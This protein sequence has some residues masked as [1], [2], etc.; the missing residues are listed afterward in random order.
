VIRPS[1]RDRPRRHLHRRSAAGGVDEGNGAGGGVPPLRLI[2]LL[3]IAISG[4]LALTA[5]PALALETHV[6]K[7]SF[8]SAGS[9][10]GQLAL[11]ENSGVAID[12]ATGDVYVADTGN[13]RVSEFEAD[14]TF[15]R[16]FGAF[17]TPTYIA[18]DNS[19]GGEGDVYVAD[20]A[21]NL[22]SKF[23][24]DGTPVTGWGTAGKLDITNLPTTPTTIGTNPLLEV[25]PLAGIAVGTAGNLFVYDARGNM[26]QFGQDGSPETVFNTNFG[27]TPVGIAVDSSNNLYL[28]R[29]FPAVEKVS[30]S[31][32]ELGLIAETE[33][34][35]G[36]TVDPASSELFVDHGSELAAFNPSG[37]RVE[38]FSG[39]G[40][41]F[42]Q[43]LAVDGASR[44][45]FVASAG[46]STIAVFEAASLPTPITGAAS[47][48]TPTT[49]TLHGEV[50]PE[51]A[52]LTECVFEYGLQAG[53]GSQVPCQQS[54][55]EIG[56]G[57][58]PVAVTANL[59]GLAPST[60]YHF[61]L[62]AANAKGSEAGAD[63][64]LRTTGP[65]TI[66]AQ[67]IAEPIAKTAATIE[68][69]I[70]PSGFETHAWVEYGTSASYGSETAPEALGSSTTD[71]ALTAHLTGL[72]AGTAYH[73]R[74]VAENAQGTVRSGQDQ[75][76]TT[77]APL[78][79]DSAS[80][81]EVS[82]TSATLNAQINPLGTPTTY[83]FEYDTTPYAE[84]EAAHGVSVPAPDAGASSGNVDI[85]RTA[86]IQ[87]LAPST[88]YHYRVVAE[89]ALDR[90][91][92]SDRIF[93]T[94]GSASAL[95]PDGRQWELASPPDKH[96]GLLYGGKEVGI[97]QAAA[98]GSAVS[99]LANAPTEA[100][101]Q[102]SAEGIQV[103]STRG[104]AGW[105]SRDIVLPHEA[106]PGASPGTAPEYRF[107]TED[108]TAAF[109][110]PFG[111]FNPTLSPEGS[112]QT[113]YLHALGSCQSSCFRPLVTAADVSPHGTRF[114][115][116]QL[117]EQDVEEGGTFS[118]AETICGP[119]FEGATGDARHVVIRSAAP[120]VIGAPPGGK[121]SGET[122][123]SLYEWSS[124]QLQLISVLPPNEAGE[125]LPAP[126]V[127][128]LEPLLGSGS[129]HPRGTARRAISAD[130][131]RIVWEY[132]GAI[133]LRDTELGHEQ[134][135]QLDSPEADCAQCE[136]EGGAGRFQIASTDGS[137]V[138]FTDTHRLTAD[139]GAKKDQPD[140]YEC[141][142]SING[143]GV[144]SCALTDLTPDEGGKGA[145]VQGDVIGASED[146]TMIYFV[147]DGTLGGAAAER[148]T[149]VNEAGNVQPP[150]ARCNLYLLRDGHSPRLVASLSGAD[151]KDWTQFQQEQPTRVSPDGHWLTFMSQRSLTGYDNTDAV[152]RQPDAEIFLYDDVGTGRLSCA[153]CNPTG[154]RPVGV[155]YGS[156]TISGGSEK[157]PTT[158]GQWE[159]TGW[160]AALV[161][162]VEAFSNFKPSYQPRYLN[163]SG[164]LYFNGLDALVPQDTNAT[165]DVYQ[166]E[167]AGVGSCSI[168][169][170]TYSPVSGGCDDLISS[171]TSP[172]NSAF[173]DASESGDDVF[174]FTG[175]RLR[176][177]DVD[178]RRDVY[179][180]H[181][182]TAEVPC[183]PEPPPTAPACEGDACQLPA[184]PPVDATPGSLTFSGAG[185]VLECR[186]G[187]VK[188][189]GKCVKKKQKKAKKHK[190]KHQKN[191]RKKGKK[192][193]GSSK[194]G[195][196]K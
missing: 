22:I 25:G 123:G 60:V 155:E 139:S 23:E 119:L 176:P 134:T 129:G 109:V 138:F 149:C 170:P 59:T 5:S 75:V 106:A 17:T 184:T 194:R 84:G 21:D 128:G 118:S 113:P 98:D 145:N 167:P 36:L 142:V 88:T 185:N 38:A 162:Q 15:V 125:E 86:L 174:F 31:G 187:Q 130:G 146:G 124:G 28:L 58:A 112:E 71:Q 157:L 52:E 64:A 99:Y 45:V 32:I 35:T 164:R 46:S 73:F 117:C 172:E 78:L 55:V 188:K 4:L 148:G 165:G 3:A 127:G 80:A 189:G 77:E 116:E 120:L 161:P 115:E 111:L 69:Q 6:F 50:N 180:A 34:T 196:G 156:L 158:R 66:D 12:Q 26:F 65:P 137:R 90:V 175:S 39:G 92:G 56:A 143:L 43:G 19:P 85:L 152:S 76:L 163:D 179:D 186:K 107:F 133:Y 91:E 108:L 79:I 83:H 37:A 177:E 126:L 171:G 57:G 29:G 81:T 20:S 42:G 140:L 132:E 122:F 154:A 97:A 190:K 102:G 63:A 168:S 166:F 27:V 53:Y 8:G 14:G 192:P 18:I 51:G 195:G 183:L 67:A 104:P 61:R 131:T 191:S 7:E 144:L 96:G 151:A 193:A 47:E 41:T 82:S 62:V 13:G 40:L 2:A 178:N 105:A 93:T 100:A 10:P 181:A 136:G 89:N 30:S 68:A 87:G 121:I 94:Q 48:V 95:L 141:R 147:A 135:I 169:A 160:V 1:F 173:I 16:N 159:S 49:A 72:S 182:C 11:L 153:S 101:P 150:G 44:D 70:N 114:G 54:S 33:P 103:L 24:A 9:G 110:Q 74:V